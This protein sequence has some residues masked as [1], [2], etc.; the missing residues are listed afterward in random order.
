VYSEFFNDVLVNASKQIDENLMNKLEPFEFSELLHY[1][2]EFL[3]GFIAERY[4]IGLKEGW[5]RAV[6]FVK[7]GINRGI[8]REINADEVRNLMVSTSYNDI[9]YKHILLPIWISAYTYKNK[10]FRYM[11]NGQTGEV[12]GKAPVSPWKV[13]ALVLLGAA[14]IAAF[15]IFMKYYG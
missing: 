6:D 7:S 15:V 10:V 8:T 2:P 3:S 12:Q 13:S 1:K 11:I 14:L 4:S 5:Q 9:K